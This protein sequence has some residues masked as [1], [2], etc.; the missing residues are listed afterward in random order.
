MN[1]TRLLVACVVALTL[2]SCA[3]AAAPT[4]LPVYWEAPQFSGIDQLGRRV[5]SSTLRGHVVVANF[6]FTNCTDI[7]PTVVTPKMLELQ[8]SF[9]QHGLLGEKVLLA[10]FTVDPERDTPEALRD[11]AGRFGADHESWRF[12]HM[13]E[14]DVQRVVTGFRLGLRR[15]RVAAG[16]GAAAEAIVH[17]GR[18]ILIDP[19]QQVRATYLPEDVQPSAVI[20]DAR[21]LLR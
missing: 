19:S 9:R 21:R 11:Y 15:D 18:F 6:I 14:E 12:I 13:S 2:A 3:T 20:S 8:K 7:C 10:S 1:A 17:S 16:D 5:D 4:P